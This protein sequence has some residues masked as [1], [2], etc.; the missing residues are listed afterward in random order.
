VPRIAC[1]ACG[2]TTQ[3]EVPLACE[4]SGF[5]ALFDA[6][7]LSLCQEL[8]VRQAA[9]LLRHQDKQLW[10]RIQ[11]YVNEAR[12]LDDMSEVKLIGID[13]T[14]PSRRSEV[15]VRHGSRLRGW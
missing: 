9:A 7:A 12:Q 2:K 14:S 10:R 3:V 5:T 6:L 13:D 1:S 15:T 4:G 8:P 11:R